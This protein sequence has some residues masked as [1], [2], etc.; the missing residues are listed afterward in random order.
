MK[1]YKD[2]ILYGIIA[3]L[4]IVLL[5]AQNIIYVRVIDNAI[6]FGIT[7]KEVKENSDDFWSSIDKSISDSQI[8]IKDS[9]KFL[10]DARS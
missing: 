6:I 7:V 8:A 9:D 1:K 4:L 2:F 5:F 10:K 3:I